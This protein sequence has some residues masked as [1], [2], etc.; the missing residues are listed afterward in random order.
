MTLECERSSDADEK[1]VAQWIAAFNARDVER[2]IGCGSP[3]IE[4]RPVRL[5]GLQRVYNG[6]DG[7][8]QWVADLAR[9]Q[10]TLVVR[11]T[12]R[13]HDGHVLAVGGLTLREQADFAPFSGL[14]RFS[15]GRISHAEHY[16][17]DGDD[18]ERLGIL[19]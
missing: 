19:D 4:V 9:H 17:S 5:I 3:D 13:L 16:L 6:H 10:V 7:L 12:R 1:I 8:R 14:Y 11:E 15:D 18:L 2:L